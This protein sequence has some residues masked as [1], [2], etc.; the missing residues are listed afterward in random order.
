[1]GGD[2]F[3]EVSLKLAPHIALGEFLNCSAQ[4]KKNKTNIFKMENDLLYG[5]DF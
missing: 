5:K 1:M 2:C 3:L 4:R